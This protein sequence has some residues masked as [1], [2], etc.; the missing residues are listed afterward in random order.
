MVKSGL[1]LGVRPTTRRA[2][3]RWLTVAVPLLAAAVAIGL[4]VMTPGSGTRQ[5]DPLARFLVAVAVIV[6]VSHLFGGLLARLRQPPVIGEVLGGLLLGPSALAAWWPEATTWL[7]TEEVVKALGM[8]AQLGL[9]IFMF[10]LGC[11]LRLGGPQARRGAVPLILIGSI[12]L[13]FLG[14]AAIALAGRE[15][16]AGPSQNDVAYVAFLGLALSITALPVL[17]RVLVDLGMDG[18]R[19]GALALTC[20]ASGDGLMWAVLTVVLG[21]SG[22]GQITSTALLCVIFGVVLWSLV[23]P[24]L[25]ALVRWTE[26]RA[27]AGQIMLPVLLAGALC[28][29]AITHVIGLHPAIGAFLFG[30][31]VPRGAAVIERLNMGLRD[32]VVT[33]LLPLFFAGIGLSTSVGLLGSSAAHWAL[34]AAVLVTAMVTKFGGVMGGARLAGLEHRDALRLGVL[35]NCRGV[36]E[37][38][39]AAIGYQHGLIN[40]LT[41]TILV[42]VALITTAVTGPAMHAI[43]IPTPD[44]ERVEDEGVR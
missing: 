10:L 11:E 39:I 13:P 30:V 27:D 24:A 38:V 28:C 32:F 17:A 19:I 15:S 43:G 9:V 44:D 12:S 21:L 26:A 25:A 36:T 2:V 14:G 20:A 6:L 1:D 5:V 31:V 18:S 29:A 42:L 8:V 22:P 35:M 33:V 23:R 7:F 37:L 16:L 4:H 41:L 3:P 40:A 34:F